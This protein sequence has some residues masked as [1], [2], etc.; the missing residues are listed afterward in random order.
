M[1][2][3]HPRPRIPRPLI[4]VPEKLPRDPPPLPQRPDNLRPQ[5]RPLAR[6][7]IRPARMPLAPRA[8]RARARRRL[9]LHTIRLGHTLLPMYEST[10]DFIAALD[11][12]GELH[13][14]KASVSPV[15]EIAQITDRTSKSP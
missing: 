13:R 2:R 12:A 4:P 8:Y 5:P 6:R 15:L 11:R 14:I 9:A 3:P 10:Q 7:R 1:H